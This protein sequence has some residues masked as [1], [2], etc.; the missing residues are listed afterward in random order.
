MK[1]LLY[2]FY[3]I[4]RIW[5]YLLII[6]P[7]IVMSP[8]LIISLLKE[9]WYPS[10][11]KIARFW[12]KIVLYGMGFY[13]KIKHLTAVNEKQ[14]FMIVANH[15]CMTDVMLMLIAVKNPFVFVGKKELS[16]Y[17]I[18]GFFY[19]RSSI[20]VDRKSKKSRFEVFQR[21]QSRIN[22]GLSICIFPEGLVPDDKSIVLSPF[23]D[24][25]FRLA[26]EHQLPILPLSFLDNKRRF[27]YEFFSGSPGPMRVIVHP[28]IATKDL[29]IDDKDQIKD[30]VW[31]LIYKDLENNQ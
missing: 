5:F 20:L 1:Y 3:I 21:A 15:T 4:W 6:I 8:A 24:G 16:K 30:M 10:F 13:P 22:Q 12:A 14:S 17:P 18:F 2:P 31:E 26:I 9:S 28:A 29:T 27:S 7:I 19:K 23:K 25:A 11:F